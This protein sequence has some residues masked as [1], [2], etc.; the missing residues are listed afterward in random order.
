MNFFQQDL[1]ASAM[2]PN[3]AGLSTDWFN[4]LP[5]F[6]KLDSGVLAGS[7]ME[8]LFRGHRVEET[9]CL[10]LPHEYDNL[11]NGE[12]LTNIQVTST[13]LDFGIGTNPSIWRIDPGTQ[14]F[15][16]LENPLNA[17]EV[18]W[19]ALM[20]QQL[21]EAFHNTIVKGGVA[22]SFCVCLTQGTAI[23][24]VSSS[25]SVGVTSI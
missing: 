15:V 19:D 24:V 2:T 14:Q 7:T 1:S 18:P 4:L 10:Q 21:L 12:K 8:N 11:Y 13:P 5:D 17:G 22:G 9:P 16:L 23:P 25:V 20:M 6:A 3:I